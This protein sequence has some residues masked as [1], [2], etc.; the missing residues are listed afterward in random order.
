MKRKS[1]FG[2]GIQKFIK[3][4]TKLLKFIEISYHS[5]ISLIN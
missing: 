5:T 1:P 3:K 4:I 2:G